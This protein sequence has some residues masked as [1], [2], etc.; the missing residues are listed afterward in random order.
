[1]LD[2]RPK[3]TEP[4]P[5]RRVLHF[6]GLDSSRD[7]A[8]PTSK[9]RPPNEPEERKHQF[10]TWYFFAAFLGVL[11]I[12]YLWLQFSQVET[13]P[14]SQFEQLLAE[15][16]ISE[17]SVGSDTIQGALK[18]PFPDGRKLFYTVRVDPTLADKLSAHGV[19]VTGAP[20]N[21][22]F[23]TILSWALPIFVFYLIWTYGIRR[24]AERQGLGGL[25]TIGNRA[26]RSMLKPTPR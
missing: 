15:N 17:V 16:K 2:K 10:A 8:G 9:H 14:Y 6:L 26:P 11:L 20:S 5:A 23:S 18:E 25:M 21:N 24:M 22:L 1:M 3:N 4:A 19:K 7:K 13:I 12:Q